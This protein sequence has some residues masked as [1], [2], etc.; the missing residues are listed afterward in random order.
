MK[1]LLVSDSHGNDEAL[2]LIANKHNDCDYYLH[3]GD[4][5]SDLEQIRPFVAVKG[6]CDFMRN[7]YQKSIILFTPLGKLY[8][9]H[10]P[11]Y[12]TS[13]DRLKNNGFKF[14][15]HGHTHSPRNEII[16]GIHIINPGAIAY[17]RSSEASYAILEIT[18]QVKLTFYH[19]E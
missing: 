8:A 10:I 18:D 5:Q 11:F 7:E 17:P 2:R 12:Q 6:N 13:I 16:E 19:L 4:S 3:L 15:L 1:I 9:E 14:Y